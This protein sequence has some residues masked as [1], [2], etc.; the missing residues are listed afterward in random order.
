MKAVA[1]IEIVQI[2]LE[3][4]ILFTELYRLLP[5][6]VALVQVGSDATEFNQVVFLQ[7][8]SKCNVVEVVKGINGSS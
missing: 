6:V 8:L 4:F 1:K 7:G 2:Y 5:S 3:E